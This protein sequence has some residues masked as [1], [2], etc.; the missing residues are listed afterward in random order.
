MRA[1]GFRARSHSLRTIGEEHVAVDQADQR[2]ATVTKA[3]FSYAVTAMD[4]VEGWNDVDLHVATEGR[5]V[6]TQSGG[7]FAACL[8]MFA[9]ACHDRTRWRAERK[10]RNFVSHEQHLQ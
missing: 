5:E 6:G 2:T 8:W 9:K 1:T 7:K 4:R 10:L 3:W